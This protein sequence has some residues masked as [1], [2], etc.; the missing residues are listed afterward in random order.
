MQAFDAAISQSVIQNAA[1]LSSTGVELSIT[2]MPF[3]SLTVNGGATLMDSQFDS[4]PGAACYP[5][6]PDCDENGTFDAAGLTPPTAAKFTSTASATYDFEL[7]LDGYGFVTLNYYHRDPVNYLISNAPQTR[8]GNVDQ[9]GLNIGVRLDNGW[10]ITL[11]CKNC[12][13]EKVPVATGIDAG[14]S[15]QYG[16]TSV[17]QSWG[18]NSVRNIGL[19]VSYGF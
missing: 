19:R 18:F 16:T 17:V 6:Q 3:E 2:A 14:D 1:S 7:P 10:D 12:T 11:F 9:F 5:Q 13:D 8:I 4:F 15:A